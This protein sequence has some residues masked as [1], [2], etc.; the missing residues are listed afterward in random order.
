MLYYYPSNNTE[1]YS[2]KKQKPDTKT[3]SVVEGLKDTWDALCSE[4]R[5]ADWDL[6]Q[7]QVRKARA[8]ERLDAMLKTFDTL[9]DR[10]KDFFIPPELQFK[11]GTTIG[12][13]MQTILRERGPLPRNELMKILL[14]GRVITN[15][16]NARVLVANAIKRDGRK[17]FSVTSD[18]KV[19]LR[20]EVN[21]DAKSQGS[22]K[23]A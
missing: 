7:A 8:V 21:G 19:E 12:N 11:Q 4:L 18:G 17:R 20:K 3:K 2:M 13:A 5:Q 15:R 6:E 16:K 9:G 10:P 14:G 23:K 1:Y 22:N